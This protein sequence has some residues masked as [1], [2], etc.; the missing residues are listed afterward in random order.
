[1]KCGIIITSSLT[2]S[3]NQPSPFP[4]CFHSSI[5]KCWFSSIRDR[6]KVFLEHTLQ[7]MR[8]GFPSFTAI[9]SA[10]C[11]ACLFAKLCVQYPCW[12]NIS[13]NCCSKVFPTFLLFIRHLL[14]IR[15]SE[16]TSRFSCSST[17]ISYSMI[18]HTCLLTSLNGGIEI[19][20]RFSV[21][22]VLC[23]WF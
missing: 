23:N 20:N 13:Q 5:E 19:T 21:H 4:H 9:T 16:T 6:E 11:P 7:S 2:L 12:C 17:T 1:M 10:G 15:P 14:S 18:V 8:Y 3:A 22:R